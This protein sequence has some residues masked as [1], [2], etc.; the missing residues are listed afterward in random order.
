MYARL[1][2]LEGSTG[3]GANSRKF[4]CSGFVLAFAR[5]LWAQAQGK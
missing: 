5:L 4:F 3:G 2:A 1:S